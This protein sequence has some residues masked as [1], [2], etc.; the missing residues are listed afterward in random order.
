MKINFNLDSSCR[1]PKTNR[2]KVKK[3]TTKSTRKI[4][5]KYDLQFIAKIQNKSF[6]CELFFQLFANIESFDSNVIW[7]TIFNV[8]CA[9]SHACD[10]K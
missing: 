4:K 2:K 10:C 5:F 6:N 1:T 9:M 7:H 3:K 8:I